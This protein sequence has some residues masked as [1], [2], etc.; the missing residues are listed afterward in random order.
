MN[1]NIQRFIVSFLINGVLYATIMYFVGSVNTISQ[2]VFSASFFGI[3]MG[4]FDL[5]MFSKRNKN[6]TDKQ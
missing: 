2:F 5:F 3:F 1:K 4:L 6:K